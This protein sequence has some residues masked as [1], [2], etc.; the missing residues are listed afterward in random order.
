MVRARPCRLS[1]VFS[2]EKIIEQQN[3]SIQAAKRTLDMVT[4][5]K[6]KLRVSEEK[7]EQARRNSLDDDLLIGKYLRKMEKYE[8]KLKQVRQVEIHDSLICKFIQACEDLDLKKIE[9]CLKLGVNV[10]G[11]SYNTSRKSGAA[12]FAL[13]DSN[14]ERAETT[15]ASI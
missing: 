2:D 9:C 3:D 6:E 1:P 10:N 14:S 4:S 12:V 15:L 13:I 8:E 5:L 11:R 7:L